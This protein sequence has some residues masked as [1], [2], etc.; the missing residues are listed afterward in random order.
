MKSGQ[1]NSD[2]YVKWAIEKGINY[3]DVAPAY[4]DAQEKLGNSLI[5]YRKKIYLAWK[6]NKR[7]RKEAEKE[8][9]ESL[10]L[11]HT[12]YF[13]VYQLHELSRL[14]ELDI[15]FGPGGVMELMKELKEKGL[16]KKLGITCHTE[17][18]ALKALELFDFDTVLFPLNW[19]MNLKY[20]MG[21]KLLKVAKEK[22]VGILCMKSMTERA[23]DND[24]DKDAQKKYNKCW[25]KPFDTDTD[26]KLLI[27]ALKYA[28][29]LGVDTIVPPGNFDHFS[30][31]VN[32]IENVLKNPIS[33]EEL[34]LLKA[35]LKKVENLPFLDV[36]TGKMINAM[37]NL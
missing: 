31:A 11:L 21:N 27:A 12:D 23:W 5:P 14:E 6:T 17:K 19:H 1:E 15:A 10:K 4:G 36:E 34:S 22:G 37:I 13:D 25:Y 9:N 26:Q 24:I 16:V 2:D 35:H 30:F 3:F 18:V 33:E 29:S 20:G 28:I 8:F 7:T 32:N